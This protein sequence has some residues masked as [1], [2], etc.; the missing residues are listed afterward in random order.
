MLNNNYTAFHF[1]VSNICINYLFLH[2][3][4]CFIVLPVVHSVV[5]RSSYHAIHTCCV[6]KP[7]HTVSATNGLAAQPVVS[8]LITFLNTKVQ[9]I[10]LNNACVSKTI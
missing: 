6:E 8:L 2:I 1:E 10:L 3:L 7:T 9:L 5:S 4:L